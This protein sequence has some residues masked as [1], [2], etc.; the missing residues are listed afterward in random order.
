M[1]EGNLHELSI[2]EYMKYSFKTFKILSS[3]HGHILTTYAEAF[4]FKMLY[5]SVFLILEQL[6]LTLS[7]DTY[8]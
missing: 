7:F 3:S 6:N 1:V 4:V 5:F 2:W 8:F